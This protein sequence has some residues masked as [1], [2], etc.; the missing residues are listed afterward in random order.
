MMPTASP[1]LAP[2]GGPHTWTRCGC[3]ATS[4]RA[5]RR[6][7]P[8]SSLPARTAVPSGLLP[9]AVLP[10][11][12][13]GRPPWVRRTTLVEG[14]PPFPPVSPLRLPNIRCRIIRIWRICF[15]D[16]ERARVPSNH[17]VQ[18]FRLAHPAP[19]TR[20]PHPS[21]LLSAASPP[22]VSSQRHSTM[23]QPRGPTAPPPTPPPAR[24]RPTSASTRRD[25]APR[26]HRATL[27]GP[28]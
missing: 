8:T 21:M 24:Q 20:L 16:R 5:C 19:P 11:T 28:P 7:L 15:A 26:T 25:I 3:A 27:H 2:C 6:F 17:R 22:C 13:A 1:K 12:G 18:S 9:V 10:P 14:T 4:L 23:G